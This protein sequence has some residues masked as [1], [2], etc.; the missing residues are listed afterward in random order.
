LEA[1]NGPFKAFRLAVIENND[2]KPVRRIVN[3]ACCPDGVEDEVIV[4]P[5]TRDENIDSWHVVSHETQLGSVSFLQDEY[6][7]KGLQE[8]RDCNRY[9][10]CYKNPRHGEGSMFLVLGRDGESYPKGEVKPV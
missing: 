10:D 4:L 5:T 3:I 7:P 9:F 1:D 2:A 6:R 8:D